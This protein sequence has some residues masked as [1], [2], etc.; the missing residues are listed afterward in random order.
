LENV[1]TSINLMYP[2]NV[3]VWHARHY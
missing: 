2:L 1:F 3:P